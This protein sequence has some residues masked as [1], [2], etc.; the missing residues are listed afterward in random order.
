MEHLENPWRHKIDTLV[1]SEVAQQEVSNL[2]LEIKDL[3]VTQVDVLN[4]LNDKRKNIELPK[5]I[6]DRIL[7][8]LDIVTGFC[9]PKYRV[10]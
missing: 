6:D 7:E 9:N 4:Y 2:L 5:A 8:V 3:K 1:A 10:W